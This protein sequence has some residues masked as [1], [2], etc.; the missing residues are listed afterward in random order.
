MKKPNILFIISDD[1]RADTMGFK[2]L[3]GAQ[4][5]NLDWLAERGCSFDACYHMGAQHEAVCAPSRAAL[6]TGNNPRRAMANCDFEINK[7]MVTLGQN[8]RSNGYNTFA[9]GKWHNDPESLNRSFQDGA[10]LF[11]DGM[12][13]HF[14]TPLQAY[15]LEGDYNISRTT[16]QNRHSSDIFADSSVEFIQNQEN[17]E[18]P[19]FLYVA[20]T[21]PHDPRTPP[22]NYGRD[23][24]INKVEL[25]ENTLPCHPW[26]I[27]DDR[28]RDELLAG[29]PRSPTE[30]TEHWAD[31]LGMVEHMDA[32]IGRILTALRQL[33]GGIENTIIVY[34]SDHGLGLG[35]HGLMGKQNLYEHSVKVPCLLSGPGVPEKVRS[36]SFIH[37]PDLF[38]TLCA[39]SDIEIPDSVREAQDLSPILENPNHDVRAFV[40][41]FYKN[42]SNMIR[43]EHWKLIQSRNESEEIHE[44]LFNL[45]QDPSEMHD[46]SQNPNFQELTNELRQLITVQ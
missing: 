6:H 37:T 14:L 30:L 31:Y 26:R 29:F 13:D 7:D 3:P 27:G 35:S 17:S 42:Y 12:D 8:F 36:S 25:P 40:R 34:T 41:C 20:F 5:P 19:W 44:Q 32:C 2:N 23:R 39:L 16:R 10:S 46:E 38:P 24:Y 11:L 18:I 43:K 1:H 22:E 28:I 45:Q 15:S 21:A 33:P 9:V 4:T